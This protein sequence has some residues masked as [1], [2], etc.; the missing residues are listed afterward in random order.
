MSQNIDRNSIIMKLFYLDRNIL[1]LYT[2]YKYIKYTL[3][4]HH[5]LIMNVLL[6]FSAFYCLCKVMFYV[7]L[8]RLIVYVKRCI[9]LRLY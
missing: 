7:I 5:Q 9:C 6:H 1:H 4:H 2:I 8:L 3:I